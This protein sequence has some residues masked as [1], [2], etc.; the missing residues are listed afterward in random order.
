MKTA[1]TRLAWMVG[2]AVLAG[3]GCSSTQVRTDHD[4]NA[5]FSRYRTFALSQGQVVNEGLIDQRDTLIKDRINSALKDELTQKGLEPTNLNPDLIVT[6]T[7]GARTMDEL[8]S[9]WGDTYA[10]TPMPYQ[11]ATEYR[12]GTLVIDVIDA[13]TNKLVWR[14]VARAEDENFRKPENIEKTVDKALDKFPSPRPG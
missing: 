2:V 14:S 13:N 4:P 6:Y 12:E 5:R 10:Y 11:W 3:L 1:S 7:A 8:T 9:Y